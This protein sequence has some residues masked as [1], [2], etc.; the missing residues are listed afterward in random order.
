MTELY[1]KDKELQIDGS[2]LCLEQREDDFSYFCYPV[3]AR[4]IGFEGSILY[5]LLEPYGD[6]VFA[7]DPETC[8]ERFVYPLAES[9]SDFLRLILACGSANP[10]EQIAWM[11]EEQFRQHL[12]EEAKLRTDEQQKLLCFLAQEF[13]LSPMEQPYRYVKQI[14][15][16]FDDSKIAYSDEYFEALGLERV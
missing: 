15:D 1:E 13:N 7:C 10:I 8:A 5:C 3:N 2:L 14:Q 4:A 16:S 9:F 11:S 12:Q 6:M